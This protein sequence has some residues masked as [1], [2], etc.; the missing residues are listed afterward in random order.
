MVESQTNGL[1]PFEQFDAP[2]VKD[3]EAK[4]FLTALLKSVNPTPFELPHIA[5]PGG[6]SA[7]PTWAMPTDGKPKALES[8]D[9]ILLVVTGKKRQWWRVKYGSGDK[10]PPDCVSS[11]LV[12]GRGINSL[13]EDSQPGEH[14]CAE[15]QWSQF[16]SARGEGAKGKDCAEKH[17]VFF[18]PPG[19]RMPHRLDI[20]ATSHKAL[21]NYLMALG[22]K[23]LLYN[24]VVTRLSLVK[25]DNSFETS[26]IVFERI[27]DVPPTDRPLVKELAELVQTSIVTA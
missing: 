17:Q 23:G 9:A 19:A 7:A 18:L 16:G 8:I 5:V 24:D 21:K 12:T 2:L 3:P 11:D 1:I 20:P 6:G 25:G 27:A 22:N 13:A 4:K 10:T 26:T 14:Q 15:C